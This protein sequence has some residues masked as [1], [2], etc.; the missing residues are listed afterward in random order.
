[1]VRLLM[2][3]LSDEAQAEMLCVFRC[4]LNMRGASVR[5]TSFTMSLLV[6]TA[7]VAAVGS[8]HRTRLIPASARTRP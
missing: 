6:R 3:R 1:M 5:L 7:V 2:F 4:L 8:S